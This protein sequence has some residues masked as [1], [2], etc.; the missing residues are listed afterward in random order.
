MPHLGGAW[1]H[2]AVGCPAHR[3]RHNLPLGV[4]GVLALDDPRD[5]E[6]IK[7]DVIEARGQLRT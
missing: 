1:V 7:V 6:K 3:A 2:N 5:L 4:L